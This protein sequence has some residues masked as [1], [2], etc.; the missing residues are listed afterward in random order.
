VT[1]PLA[2]KV[3]LVTGGGSGLGEAIALRLA[4]EGANVVV[5]GRRRALIDRV[6]A[7]I[8]GLAVAADVSLEKDVATFFKTCEETYGRLDIL[9]NNAGFSGGGLMSP[10]DM[11][12]EVWDRTFA[13][14]TRGV[15]LCIKHALPLLKRQGGTIVNV[16]S[17]AGLKPNIRQIAYGASKAAII[18]L[19]KSVADEVGAYGVR[20]NAI[21]PGAVDTGIFRTNATARA[22]AAG[23]TVEDDRERIAQNSALGRLTTCEEVATGVFFL[24]GDSSGSMTGAHLTMDAGKR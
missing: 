21:C 6:A 12:M 14:N 22:A 13:V 5:V 19:T 17:I 3:A 24:A 11:D 20:V 15:M 1:K 8:G 23:V 18:N 4:S 7:D 10:E 9:V 16:A 2:N